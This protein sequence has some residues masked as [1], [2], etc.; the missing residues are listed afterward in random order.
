MH[1]AVHVQGCARGEGQGPGRAA[2]WILQTREGCRTPEN[3]DTL[4]TG[5]RSHSICYGGFFS[6]RGLFY[7]KG[8]GVWAVPRKY[9]TYLIKTV[10]FTPCTVFFG[11]HRPSLVLLSHCPGKAEAPL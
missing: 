10:Y 8:K 3:K 11:E 2:H 5:V 1:G 7:H 9:F 4:G 6:D